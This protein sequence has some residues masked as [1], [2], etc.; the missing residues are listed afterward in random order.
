MKSFLYIPLILLSGI[1]AFTACSEKETDLGV[2]LQDPATLFDGNSVTAYGSACTVFDDSLLTSGLRYVLVGFYSNPTFGTSEAILYTQVSI[3][4]D[5]GV[6]F[7]Q[8]FTIDSVVLSLA[9]SELYPAKA[10]SKSYRDL[11]FEVYQ[12]SECMMKDSAYYASNSIDIN[13]TVFFDDIVRLAESDSMVVKIPLNDNF[14][15]LLQNKSYATSADFVEA[16]KGLRIRIAN[17]GTPVMAT[18]NMSA[19]A[20]T[21]TAYYTYS[22]NGDAINGSTDFVVGQTSPHFNQYINNYSSDLSVFNTNINDSIE[23]S[24]QVFLC[25]MGGTNIKLNFN[26]FI[27]Q[28]KQ[29]HPLAI[30]HYAELLLPVANSSPE[31]RPET[32]VALKSYMDGAVANIPDFYDSHSGYDG[33]YDKTTGCYRLRITQH[34]QKL[35]KSGFDLGTLLVIEGRRSSAQHAIINGSDSAATNGN[36][37]R[38]QFIYSE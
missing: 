22:N 12:L 25:P 13:G 32:I 29:E 17:D 1:L 6:D 36:P 9:V 23:G 30:I 19:T 18:L 20:T 37:I 4:N 2:A 14:K 33:T 24:Q 35:V 5:N 11:H 21:M 16:V 38:I 8:N 28:F 15:A 34:L 3:D 7:S 26:T 31:D 27:Q 10:S